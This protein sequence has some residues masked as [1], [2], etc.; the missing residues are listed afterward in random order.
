MKSRC[1]NPRL[2][3]LKGSFRHYIC[4]YSYTDEVKRLFICAFNI[5]TC[6]FDWLWCVF[7][8]FNVIFC[9]LRIILKYFL[10]FLWFTDCLMVG[11]SIYPWNHGRKHDLSWTLSITVYAFP[12]ASSYLTN[13]YIYIGKCKC[14]CKCK[15]EC[16]CKCKCKCACLSISFLDIC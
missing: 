5:V 8:V 12:R 1:V 6:L 15:C 10:S 7:M 2:I 11:F 16:G 3:F 14:K 4:W 13:I 9:C